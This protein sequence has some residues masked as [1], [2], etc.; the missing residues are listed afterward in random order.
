MTIFMACGPTDCT[1]DDGPACASK[2]AASQFHLQ[3]FF[4]ALNL[5]IPVRSEQCCVLHSHKLVG[6]TTVTSTAV[7]KQVAKCS[8][9][10]HNET[11]PQVSSQRS[12]RAINNIC[13]PSRKRCHVCTPP[14]CCP[15]QPLCSRH[16]QKLHVE[17]QCSVGRDDTTSTP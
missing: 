1:Q 10:A 7:C 6:C 17:D 3:E 2:L 13:L 8:Q 5:Y 16:T 4:C 12:T 15:V 11:S 9:T 14:C